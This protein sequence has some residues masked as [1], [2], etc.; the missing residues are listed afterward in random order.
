M[1]AS[2]TSGV[3][4]MSG[5]VVLAGIIM[6]LRG[7]SEAF[8]GITALVNQQYLFITNNGLIVT[9]DNTTA[10]GWVQLAVGVLVLA[11]GFSLLHGSNWAR[12]FAVIFMGFM[13]LANM[14]FLGVFPLWAIIAMVLD[15]FVI[16]A[17]VIQPEQRVVR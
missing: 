2:S 4:P 3:T 15:L 8:L 5:W 11:A 16:Y 9:T 1:A 10:W 13:F 12:I 17:L 7:A 6:I 14:V